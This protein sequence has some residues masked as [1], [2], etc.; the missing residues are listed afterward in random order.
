MLPVGTAA[1]RSTTSK[2]GSRPGI[3]VRVQLTDVEQSTSDTNELWHAISRVGRR[4]IEPEPTMEP[5]QPVTGTDLHADEDDTNVD[6]PVQI[7]RGLR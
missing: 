7:D 2:V 6:D 4:E 1:T 3:P 5:L